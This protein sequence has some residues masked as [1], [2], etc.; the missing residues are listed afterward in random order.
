[1][2]TQALS[3]SEWIDWLDT[4]IAIPIVPWRDGRID[5]T[6][7][8]KNIDYLLTH[9]ALDGGRRR[10]ISVA[11]TSL[12]HHIDYDDQL[13]LMDETG[14]QCGDGALFI[15]GLVP[16]PLAQAARLVERQSAN[17]RPP[18]A[19]LIMPL[20]GLAH[21]HGVYDAYMAFAERLGRSCGA[22][23]LLYYQN[24]RDR[25][26]SVRLVRDS[27]YFVGI[28]IGT[29]VDDTAPL[30]EGVGGA[31]AVIWGIGDRCS[32]AIRLGARGHT[33]GIGLVCAKLCDQINNA[34]RRGDYAAAERL[35]R[36][37]APLEEIRFA[38][39]RI[40]NYSAVAAA[41]E[42]AGFADVEPGSGAPFQPPPP[43]PILERIRAAIEPLRAFH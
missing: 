23:F 33:S 21:P 8:A 9:N 1:M 13:Q 31:A 2:Q 32:P 41:L 24:R 43:P 27:P 10:A 30:V 42:L 22:R 40:Y 4:V 12:L 28:K 15:A 7:H 3:K 14:R 20:A 5:F 34:V 6:G 36:L 35:E 17:K 26:V 11:G 16:N 38:N 19:Y 25:D 18:D 29:N 37:V 39:D